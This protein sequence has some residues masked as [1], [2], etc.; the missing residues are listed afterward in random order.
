MAFLREC[1]VSLTLQTK[2]AD[3]TCSATRSR[4][5]YRRSTDS[6]L[7]SRACESECARFLRFPAISPRRTSNPSPFCSEDASGA[8]VRVMLFSQPMTSY[9]VVICVAWVSHGQ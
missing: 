4:M 1:T 6:L 9:G 3:A 7:E 5:Q 8:V 2:R